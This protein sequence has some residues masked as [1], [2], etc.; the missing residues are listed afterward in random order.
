MA[1]YASFLWNDV[2]DDDE[3]DTKMI[4]TI[5]PSL[6]TPTLIRAKT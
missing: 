5:S 6:I 3:I 1:S 2:E 4:E